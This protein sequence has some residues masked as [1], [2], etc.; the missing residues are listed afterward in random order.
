M[1]RDQEQQTGKRTM[2]MIVIGRVKA[3]VNMKHVNL[4]NL[5]QKFGGGGMFQIDCIIPLQWS[6]YIIIIYHPTV[7]NA[8]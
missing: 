5:F 8:L 2:T 6:F 3:G 1:Q 7:C 4:N